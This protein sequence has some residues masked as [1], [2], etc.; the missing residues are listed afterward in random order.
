VSQSRRLAAVPRTTGPCRDSRPPTFA[1]VRLALR[2]R[3]LLLCSEKEGHAYTSLLG[4][5]DDDIWP[6]VRSL[7]DYKSTFPQWNA[8]DLKS[9]VKGL[10][11]AGL[12]LLAQTLVYDPAH[13]ISGE[14][15]MGPRAQ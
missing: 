15:V 4:T 8:V 13:R 12:D 14:L 3:R 9:A 5:P 7:P 6:G 11:D 2:L 1:F 10:D